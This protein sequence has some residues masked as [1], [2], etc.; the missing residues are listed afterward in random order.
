[1]SSQVINEPPCPC[2]AIW[3]KQGRYPRYQDKHHPSPEEVD[4]KDPFLFLG[5][6]GMWI[7]GLN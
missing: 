2:S 5:Q 3:W 7:V 4:G 6:A 1:L